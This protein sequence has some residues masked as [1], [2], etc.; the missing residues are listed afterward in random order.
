MLQDLTTMRTCHLEP[1]PTVLCCDV[2]YRSLNTPLALVT[3]NWTLARS[4]RSQGN[5]EMRELDHRIRVCLPLRFR[6]LLVWRGSSGT[7]SHLFH[8][9][10][11]GTMTYPE[12]DDKVWRSGAETINARRAP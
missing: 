5:L 4:R 3:F 8:S 7:F 10:Y 1:Q 9:A 12:K 11:R 2:S 6:M